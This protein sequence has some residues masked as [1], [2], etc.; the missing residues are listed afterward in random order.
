MQADSKTKV[1]GKI[2]VVDDN[3]IIQRAVYFPLRDAGYKV[4]MT[5]DVSEAMKLIRA[6]QPDLVILDLSF[7]LDASNINGPIQD[8]FYLI[9]WIHQTVDVRKSPVVIISSTDPSVYKERAAA[10]GVR[11]CFHK[12]LDKE[13]LLVSVQTILAGEPPGQ[14]PPNLRLRLA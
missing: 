14:M 9:D 10:A 3:P 2:L 6:E 1:T 11:A 4:L 7:P 13:K 8:G 5:G 12:P